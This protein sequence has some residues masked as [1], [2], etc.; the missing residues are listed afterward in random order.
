MIAR[1][2]KL[3][4]I[5]FHQSLSAILPKV[6]SVITALIFHKAVHVPLLLLNYQKLPINYLFVTDQ[7]WRLNHFCLL[8]FWFIHSE[9]AARVLYE[10][11]AISLK[12]SIK[13]K[14][15]IYLVYWIILLF[16]LLER[17]RKDYWNITYIWK[18]YTRNI[19]IFNLIK[20]I[21]LDSNL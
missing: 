12:V 14:F 18:I 2:R 17:N 11:C 5:S 8:Q 9:H 6:T 7:L 10:V 16:Y 15:H 13:D 19:V 20:T 4:S 1:Y 3:V 21:F